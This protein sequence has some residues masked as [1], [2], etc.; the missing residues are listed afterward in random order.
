MDLR[1]SDLG[2]LIS[3]DAL[4]AEQSVTAAAKRLG[5]SQPALS[6]Q[7]AR[8]RDLFGDAL[9]VG[10]AHGMTPTPRA[11][12]LREPLHGLL[13]A[14]KTL[15]SA[16]ASFDPSSA[17]RTFQIG[18]TDLALAILMPPLLKAV[19]ETAPGVRLA[20]LPLVAGEYARRMERGEIDLVVTTA[21]SAPEGFPAL[22]LVDEDFRVIWR[23]GHPAIGKR[24]TLK[25]FCDQP[26]LLVSPEGGGFHGITD[27]VL[28]SKGLKRRVVG[29]LPSFLLAPT[30]VRC[31]DCLAV[32]PSRL[33]ALDPV[34]LQSAAVPVA[35]SGFS[36]YMSWHP[37]MKNDPGHRWMRETIRDRCR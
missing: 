2:L 11:E 29:S 8:L 4:L 6:A 19:S 37:R 36:L 26:H 14:L 24:L 3:L 7:L 12:A 23:S 25:A 10:N 17:Q 20:A 32:V 5:I 9:L 30:A 28:K 33:A 22:K 21:A 18:A 1:R 27:E 15:V 34:G 16:K 13:D 31:S 35:T